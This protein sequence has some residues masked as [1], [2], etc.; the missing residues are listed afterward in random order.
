MPAS[1]RILTREEKRPPMTRNLMSATALAAVLMLVLFVPAIAFSQTQ[2]SGALLAIDGTVTNGDSVTPVHLKI[3][4]S[5]IH[6]GIMLTVPTGGGS[7]CVAS[8]QIPTDAY[9]LQ[10][11]APTGCD[12]GDPFETSQGIGSASLSAGGS[13]FAIAT[14]YLENGDTTFCTSEGVTPSICANPDTGFLTVTNSGNDFTGTITLSGIA[15]NPNGISSSYCPPGGTASD[16]FTGLLSGAGGAVTLA[17]STDSSNCG[18]FNQAQTQTLTKGGAVTFLAGNDTWTDAAVNN[19]GGEQITF[20][21]VPTRQGSFSPGSLFVGDQCNPYDDFSGP[22]SPVCAPFL[23]TCSSASDC[24]TYTHQV[25]TTYGGELDQGFPHF[26][27]AS[28]AT[29]PTSNFDTNIFLSY[30]FVGDPVPTKRGGGGGGSFIVPT[31]AST[32][33]QQNSAVSIKGYASQFFT[34]I[35]NLP[36]VNH[37]E[38][39][40]PIPLIWQEFDTNNLLVK[41]PKFFSGGFCKPNTPLASC[42]ANSVALQFVQA[43]CATFTQFTTVTRANAVGNAVIFNPFAIPRTPIPANTFNVLAVP[44]PKFEDTCQ[45]LQVV[46]TGSQSGVQSAYSARFHFD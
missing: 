26:L 36:A 35:Q 14:Q 38:E 40:L 33:G 46:V 13:T 37:W 1:L 44:F 9:V 19:L 30:D 6:T 16:S 32:G 21:P 20:L 3:Y 31:F 8:D 43:D 7:T 22:N 29:S 2:T 23:L 27:K 4:D 34:P 42:P 5:Q 11:G 10:G 41:T 12:P 45:V 39:F 17:L 24:S 18:G 25:I 15:L 28:G